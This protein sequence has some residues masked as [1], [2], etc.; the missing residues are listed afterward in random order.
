M[1]AP[2]AA[3]DRRVL[4]V[5]ARQRQLQRDRR[6]GRARLRRGARARA[7]AQLLREGPAFM[8]AWRRGGT[9]RVPDP[10]RPG[11]SGARCRARQAADGPAHRGVARDGAHRAEG[12][13]VAGRDV[14]RA[15]RP[16]V[17]QLRGRPA[18]GAALSEGRQRAV[19]R[20]LLGAAGPLPRR[21]R[22]HGRRHRP[23]RGTGAADRGAGACRTRHGFRACVAARGHGPGG[24]P[25]GA[26]PA[27]H[28]RGRD[29]G[30]AVRGRRTSLS[31]GLLDRAGGPRGRGSHRA[32]RIPARARVRRGRD[33]AGGGAPPCA[34]APCRPLGAVG[35]HRLHRLGALHPRPATHPVRLCP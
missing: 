25:R 31:G 30:E 20:H 13:H 23:R 6:A 14:R 12:R 4:V 7:A 28:A 10:G 27:R 29:R 11:R 24:T 22:A 1:V 35:R 2:G 15:P 21:R 26:L 33:G 5:G 19:R 8:A 34:A 16:A 17:S 18:F 3:A 9:L 32:R